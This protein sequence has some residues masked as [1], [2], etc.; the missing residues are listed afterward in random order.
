MVGIG[1]SLGLIVLILYTRRKNWVSLKLKYYLATF[2]LLIGTI[3]ILFSSKNQNR[4]LFYSL[5]MPVFIFLLDRLFSNLSK[6]IHDRD[7]YLYLRGSPDID[8]TIPGQLYNEHI[9]PSDIVFSMALLATIMCLLALGAVL[10][11]KDDLYTR[12]FIK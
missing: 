10:F 4:F 11:G 12:W 6:R 3:G 9:K 1:F 5:F 8:E 2:L 7:F